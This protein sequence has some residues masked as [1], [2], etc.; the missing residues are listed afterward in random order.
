[1]SDD[2][3][4][5]RVALVMGAGSSRPGLSIGKATAIALARSGARV[6][7]VD[8][9][10]RAA[11]DVAQVI[12]DEGGECEPVTA[13]VTVCSDVQRAVEKAVDRFG[14]IH[15]LQNNVGVVHLGGPVDLS[16]E[17]WLRSMQLNVGSAF[18]AC[19][20]VLPIMERQGS[21]VI[22][23]IS[24]IAGVRWVGIDMIAYSTFKGALN[25][26]TQ[27]VALQYAPKGIRANVVIV[28]RMDTPILRESLRSLYPDEESLIADKASICPTGTLGQPWDI[29]GASVFLASDEARYINGVALPVD[30]G[31]LYQS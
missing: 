18:L 9:D 7:A 28:G 26:F 19:K 14:T 16:E 17:A 11:A 22:T 4:K 21:G 3:L 10:E 6:V 8:I 12:R 25:S 31:V 27:T 15:I 20:H 1:M 13:D 24:S 30:G 23:S 5:G 29:A 2:R